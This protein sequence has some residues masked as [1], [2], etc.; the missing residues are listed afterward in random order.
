MSNVHSRL[1]SPIFCLNKPTRHMA[2]AMGKER[3]EYCYLWLN[4]I[5]LFEWKKKDWWW[6]DHWKDM[7]NVLMHADGYNASRPK[8]IHICQLPILHTNFGITNLPH[9]IAV[10]LS[11]HFRLP[12]SFVVRSSSGLVSRECAMCMDTIRFGTG[13]RHNRLIFYLLSKW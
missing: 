11:H 1:C 10:T 2:S 7:Y 5:L 4:F 9:P 8:Q 12:F 13:N 6:C 3:M